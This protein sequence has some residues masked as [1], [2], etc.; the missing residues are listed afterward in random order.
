MAPRIAH[1]TAWDHALA[2][3]R[4][5]VVEDEP[6]IAFML[7]D[8]LADAGAAVTTSNAGCGAL[9]EVGRHAAR[10]DA[11]VVDLGLPDMDGAEVVARLRAACPSLPLVV[12]TGFDAGRAGRSIPAG[13]G[14]ATVLLKP[15]DPAVLVATIASL[16]AEAERGALAEGVAA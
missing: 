8:A 4:V 12:A 3:R 11:A 15:F 5:L 7:E 9:D 14:P 13:G 10:F 1:P 16:V 2:G 6:L